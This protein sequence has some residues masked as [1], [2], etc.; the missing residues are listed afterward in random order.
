MITIRYGVFETNSS[1]SHSI[2][3]NNS[4]SKIDCIDSEYII[5]NLL[6]GRGA[7]HIK[8]EDVTFSR[9]PFRY[10]GKFS[11]KV[12]YALACRIDRNDIENIIRKYIPEFSSF[13]FVDID[14]MWYGTDDCI[15]PGWLKSNNVSLEDF[16][17]DGKYFV[18]C[19]GDEYC[20]YHNM[21]KCNI[22]SN[23]VS[24][25]CKQWY[26]EDDE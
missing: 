9:S 12:R 21:K 25:T 10:L 15:L 22:I 20:I 4:N 26:E 23:N 6:D 18:I 16:L 8:P 1:S 24:T 2:C 7:W 14:S 11:E 3:I 5:T 13:D 19:D 17:T